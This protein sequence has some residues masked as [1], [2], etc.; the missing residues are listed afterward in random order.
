M[1]KKVIFDGLSTL[2]DQIKFID[3]IVWENH[4]NFKG[5]YI[6][7]LITNPQYNFSC[8]LVKI[9]NNNEIGEH[10]HENQIEIHDIISGEGE[11]T[12]DNQIIKY[13]P[14]CVGVIPSNTIHSVKSIKNDLIIL[15]KFISDK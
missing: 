8:L 12:I 11:L 5:V 13:S 1:H 14:G 15:A 7:N 10:K 6:K 9:E 3:D 2:N 4:P